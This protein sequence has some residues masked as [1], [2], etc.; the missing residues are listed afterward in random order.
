MTFLTL[1]LALVLE[2][3]SSWRHRLQK[4]GW[5]LS[6]LNR[7]QGQTPWLAL[8]VLVVLPSALLALVLWL[9]NP[10]MYGWLVS[11]LHVLVLLY[12]L[13]RGEVM[14]RLG[15]FRDA[16]RR[17]DQVGAKHVAERDLDIDSTEPETLLRD[18]QDYLVWQGYQGFFAVIFWYAL[19][20]PVAALAYRL[21]ILMQEH[22][23][24]EQR[25]RATRILH[26][27][28]FIP[29][30]VLATTFAVVG[31]FSAVSQ[32]LLHDLLN[33]K[34]CNRQMITQAGRAAAEISEVQTGEEGNQTFDQ[35]WQLLV[36]SAIAWY[37]LIAIWILL[38]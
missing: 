23:E 26:A 16:W 21:L 35:L 3:F 28:D 34:A 18:V 5:W 38:A 20:G 14:Q 29:V 31:H 9:L 6:L 11:P 27:V 17:D 32:A 13:G 25:Q 24:P 12:S 33:W 2:H 19:L 30:R 8:V 4:D 10:L 7:A 1:L 37:A 22:T 36:R 15:P